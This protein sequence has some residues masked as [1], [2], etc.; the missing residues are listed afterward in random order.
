MFFLS[1]LG[2][3]VLLAPP[4]A[5]PASRPPV[6]DAAARALALQQIEAQIQSH[7]VYPDRRAGIIGRLSAAAGAGR[8]DTN[9]PATFAQRVSED[10]LAATSDSHL[11]LRYE[12]DWYS[13]AR[14]PP[15]PGETE[16]EVELEREIARDTNHG[17]VEM[18]V[19]PGNIRYLK[20]DGF[21]WV[22]D[23]TGPVY[24]AAMRFLK[25]GRAIII[26]LR[27]N[28]GGWTQGPKYLLSHFLAAN[29]LIATFYDANGAAEQYRAVDYVPSGRI[30]GVP[31]YVL[32]DGHS[33]SA[34]EMV[35]YTFQQY[36]LGELIGARTE[37]AANVSDDFPVAPAF[38][39]SVSTGRTVQPVSN[40]DWE[41]TGVSPTIPADPANALEVAEL[42]AIDRLLPTSAPGMP[43]YQ[44]AW[45]KPALEAALHP[46][47][48]DEE[49][50]RR[51]AGVYGAAS[52]AFADHA[53]WL[54]RPGRPPNRLLP[55]TD[56]GLFRADDDDTLRAKITAS[57]LDVLRIDPAYS[58]TYRK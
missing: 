54:H 58:A 30:T 56:A 42:R 32:I 52:I 15:R 22:E 48:L 19:L 33:R 6:L 5:A 20:I 35:A 14:L 13:S 28:G 53:L 26:D 34:A 37:G 55:M 4:A 3:M 11:Y 31:A 10:L 38:R 18:R 8:Y 46:V 17:L 1:L 12:P 50:L 23:E 39:L 2:A 57:E 29:T 24:D 21:D 41:G 9:D 7:Y 49:V 44:L 51:F 47:T 45:A 40:T 36:R 27:G 43:R 25:G 16:R